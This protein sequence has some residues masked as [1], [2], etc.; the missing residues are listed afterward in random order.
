M[1]CII[2]TVLRSWVDSYAWVCRVNYLTDTFSHACLGRPVF[3]AVRIAA[4]RA[5]TIITS[6]R[7]V[8]ALALFQQYLLLRFLLVCVWICLMMGQVLLIYL[9]LNPGV[10]SKHL[11]LLALTVKHLSF[12]VLSLTCGLR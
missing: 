7:S 6:M 1:G 10:R 4:S 8:V 12:L 9:V 2:L 11:W 3:V 5:N